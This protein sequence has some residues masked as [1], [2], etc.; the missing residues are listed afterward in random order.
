MLGDGLAQDMTA[1]VIPVTALSG[2]AEGIFVEVDAV[3]AGASRVAF[4]QIG[5]DR[6]QRTVELICQ[7]QRSMI[8]HQLSDIMPAHVG[9]EQP[10][11]AGFHPPKRIPTDL[12]QR[13]SQPR[14]VVHPPSRALTP[15][16]FTSSRFTSLRFTPLR[17]TSSRPAICSSPPTASP[18]IHRPST[19]HRS[20]EPA[21][22]SAAW[23]G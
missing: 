6:S 20:P 7:P 12:L 13:P 19:A 2:R 8:P 21:A 15:H 1:F 14:L 10:Q 3:L 5:A 17:L 22:A 18:A 16:L 11:P 9:G 4:G 23:W